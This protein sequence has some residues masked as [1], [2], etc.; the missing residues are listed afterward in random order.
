MAYMTIRE[1][2]RRLAAKA[3]QKERTLVRRAE[4]RL[5]YT[6]SL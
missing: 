1:A 5:K 2:N 6:G 3:V 4:R